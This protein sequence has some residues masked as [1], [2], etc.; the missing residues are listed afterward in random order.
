M[1]TIYITKKQKNFVHSMPVESKKNNNVTNFMACEVLKIKKANTKLCT[2][3]LTR[4]VD[5]GL[6]RCCRV[7]GRGEVADHLAG[8]QAGDRERSW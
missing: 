7:N 3:L 6:G 8:H 5:R 4:R 2:S 1:S